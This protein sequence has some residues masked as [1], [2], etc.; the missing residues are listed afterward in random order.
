MS[1]RKTK[2]GRRKAHVDK[3]RKK[4]GKVNRRKT[5]VGRWKALCV[6]VI[7]GRKKEG[8]VSRRKTKEGSR[9]AQ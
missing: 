7:Q 5:M 6:D 2:G 1:R 4:E 8:T 3:G 9:K